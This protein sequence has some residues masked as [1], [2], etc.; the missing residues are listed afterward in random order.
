MLQIKQ[1]DFTDL[2][3]ATKPDE[4]GSPGVQPEVIERDPGTERLQCLKHLLLYCWAMYRRYIL[5]K[6]HH[7][8]HIPTKIYSFIVQN[9]L[10]HR[11]QVPDELVGK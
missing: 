8:K 11:N 1:R 7:R 5:L 4:F 2:P 10:A 3:T 6:Y 9:W